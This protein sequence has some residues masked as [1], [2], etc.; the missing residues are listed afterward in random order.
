MATKDSP[1]KGTAAPK[2]PGRIAQIRQVFTASREADPNIGWW[3][4]LAFLGV[5]VLAAAV[6]VL[7][8][9]LVYAMLVGLPVAVLAATLVMSRRAERAAYQRIEGQPGAAVAALSSLRRGWFVEQ[10]PVA[11]EAARA[12]DLSSAAMV[13]RVI[14]RP[15]VVLVAE[16]PPARAQKLL[17][18]ERRRVERVAPGVPVTLLRVGDG[19]GENEVAIRKLNKKVQRMKPVLTKDEVSAVNKRLRALGTLRAPV[20]QGIDPTRARVDRRAMRGR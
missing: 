5:L 4:L 14:G 1:R 2:K 18:A 11:A 9:T 19:D 16:G 10:Q 15:G 20:P 7:T 3:M 8:G 17:A 13:F 6:G 12:G